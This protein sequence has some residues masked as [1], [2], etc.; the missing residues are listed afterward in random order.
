MPSERRQ[1]SYDHRFVELVQR[2]GDPSIAMA[3]GVPRSTVAGWLRRTRRAVVTATQED[4]SAAELRIRVA[5]LE[6]RCGRLRAVLRVLFVLFRIVKPDLAHLR[7]PAPEKE[8]LLRAVDRTRGVLGLRRVLDL[9]GFSAA[10]LHAWRVAATGCQ[11][12]DRDSCPLTTPEALTPVEVSRMREMVTA[13]EYR[14]V[15]T[16]RLALLAQ[17]LGIVGDV[18]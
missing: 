16:T 12:E 1:R 6:K 14:H 3:A 18:N 10:R 13:P 15:P 9:F 7:I 8:R 11:L 17:R 2:T 4:A 5:V